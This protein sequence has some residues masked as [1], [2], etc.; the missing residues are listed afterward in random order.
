MLLYV[1][2]SDL[3][4]SAFK[5]PLERNW[6][7]L[8]TVLSAL[9]PVA[10]IAAAWPILLV[11]LAYAEMARAPRLELG[12]IRS[13]M[14]SGLGLAA[15]LTAAVSFAYVA[16]ERDKKLDLAYFRTSR[17]GE[18]TRRIVRNLDQPIEIAVFFPSANEVR[19][20]VDDY[21]QDLVK[22]IRPD[23]DHALR[24]RHRPDQGEG[25]RRQHQ[26][27]PGVRAR[28]QAA[29]SSACRRTSRARRRPSRRW[30]RRCS[31]ACCR[32]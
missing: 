2:Q 21:L 28:Q 8:S 17:P 13:A 22:E 27:H 1:I 26:R 25:V 31:S 19:D 29:S 24:L 10:W 15:T 14:L 4:A 3:W 30:T 12:R 32:S 16:S 9:W 18:V 6:P 23:Q 20:E 7:K 5:Q 11:E